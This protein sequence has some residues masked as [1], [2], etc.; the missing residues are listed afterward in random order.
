[1]TKTIRK[2]FHAHEL[3]ESMLLKYS[4]YPRQSTG[5][6]QSLA[7]GIFHR[8][9]TNNTKICMETKKTLSNQG[10]LEK[11]EQTCRGGSCALI[12]NYTAK[13]Q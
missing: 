4:Y 13:L 3:E 9:R 2:L 6:M 8:T 7:K 10:N 12:S 11:E 1:M 5:S